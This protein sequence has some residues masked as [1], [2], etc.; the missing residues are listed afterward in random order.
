[1]GTAAA[2]SPLTFPLLELQVRV[3]HGLVVRQSF[4]L[5]VD[6]S[7]L[8]EEVEVESLGG[9]DPLLRVQEQHF[10]QDAHGC[11]RSHEGRSDDGTESTAG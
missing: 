1:M 6:V 10:F 2:T 11:G 7:E 4:G 9:A 5:L 3:V 8:A